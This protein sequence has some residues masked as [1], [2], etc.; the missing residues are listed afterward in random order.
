MI[1]AALKEVYGQIGEQECFS[2][3]AI[4]F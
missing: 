4:G 3:L 2:R 1:A